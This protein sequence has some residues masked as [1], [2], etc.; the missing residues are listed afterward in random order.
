MKE[1]DEVS[2]PTFSVASVSSSVPGEG[3]AIGARMLL[4]AG[5][6]F[7]LSFVQTSFVQFLSQGVRGSSLPTM[8]LHLPN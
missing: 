7:S 2:D 5:T 1:V 8:F 3:G 4:P 6:F